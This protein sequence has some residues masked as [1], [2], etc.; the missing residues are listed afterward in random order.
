[1][2]KLNPRIAY[3]SPANITI[4]ERVKECLRLEGTL[5]PNGLKAHELT[6][7]FILTSDAD[8]SVIKLELGFSER[9]K[10][11]EEE[12]T[13]ISEDGIIFQLPISLE[14]GQILVID[15]DDGEFFFTNQNLFSVEDN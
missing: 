14:D 2:P 7:V 5:L 4:T 15:Y 9:A 13:N 1:M 3:V 8:S 11:S 12:K 10:L 6:P